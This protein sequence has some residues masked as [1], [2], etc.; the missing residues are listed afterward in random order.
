M[1]LQPFKS[2]TNLLSPAGQSELSGR[3]A[4]AGGT[5]PAAV[6]VASPCRRERSLLAWLWAGPQLM[7]ASAK[8][9][10]TRGRRPIPSLEQVGV[11]R[12]LRTGHA[13][14]LGLES[15]GTGPA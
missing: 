14:A 2:A 10:H 9:R 3:A 13:D 12:N 15:I 7:V 5:Q 4:G 8:K 1:L 11:E 6:L